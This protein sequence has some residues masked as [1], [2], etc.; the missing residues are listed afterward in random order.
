LSL[1][2]HTRTI[3]LL[4][5]QTL[6]DYI[7]FSLLDEIK[8]FIPN[9]FAKIPLPNSDYIVGIVGI[10]SIILATVF[11]C[12]LVLQ[13][14]RY[15]E[16]KKKKS[17][18]QRIVINTHDEIKKQ[19]KQ[20]QLEQHCDI[21]IKEYTRYI[22]DY[23]KIAVISLQEYLSCFRYWK[24]FQQHLYT[25]HRELYDLIGQNNYHLFIERMRED[26]LNGIILETQTFGGACFECLNFHY[27]TEIL[28]LQLLLS[29]LH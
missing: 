18:E 28:Q 4:I 10:I 21:L 16:T 22:S 2:Q 5:G 19:E 14:K 29:Q 27:E 6:F 11:G 1:R 12:I 24:Q 17:T 23:P 8:K 13:F 15:L 26:L 3:G 25:G 7:A 20:R 9:I